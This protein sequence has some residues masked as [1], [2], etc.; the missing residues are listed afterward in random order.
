MAD[1]HFNR[2]H[3]LGLDRAREIAAQWTAELEAEHG[4]QCTLET[5]AH[6]DWVHF[7]RSGVSGQ[8]RVTAASF[9]IEAQLGL[10]FSAFKPMVEAQIAQKIDALLARESAPR[11]AA[12]KKAPAAKR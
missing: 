1:I 12:L 4:M 6:E 3:R 11:H 10:L 5:G 7:K 9:E 8:L 2:P